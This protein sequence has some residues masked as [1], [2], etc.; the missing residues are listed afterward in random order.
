MDPAGLTT[1]HPD[2]T[3]SAAVLAVPLGA[4]LSDFPFAPSATPGRSAKPWILWLRLSCSRLHHGIKYNS[5]GGGQSGRQGL[6]G[7]NS[8]L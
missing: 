5:V 3:F 8:Q 7:A 4:W 2:S 1:C 6:K